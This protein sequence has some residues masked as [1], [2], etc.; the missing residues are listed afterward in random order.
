[1]AR[2]LETLLCFCL[3]VCL[4]TLCSRQ[5]F[6]NQ[7]SNPCPLHWK[8]G[9]LTTGQP[10]KFLCS[11]FQELFTWFLSFLACTVSE[12]AK[13]LKGDIAIY[14]AHFSVPPLLLSGILAFQVPGFVSPALEDC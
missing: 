13:C 2:L 7:G 10:G 5:N 4:A 14:Q 1:M 11:V 3:F 9:V 12:S 8:H 6:P